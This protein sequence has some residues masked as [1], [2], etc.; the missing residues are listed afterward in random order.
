L[1]KEKKHAKCR[2]QKHPFSKPDFQGSPRNG[3]AEQE[4]I[5][6]SESAT[7]HKVDPKNAT[8]ELIQ[9]RIKNLSVNEDRFFVKFERNSS[10]RIL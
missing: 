7:A 5:N 1:L 3:S 6:I 8:Y 10:T 9:N 4:R 2:N